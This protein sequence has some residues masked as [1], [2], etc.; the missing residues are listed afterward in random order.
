MR[1]TIRLNDLELAKLKQ[2]QALTGIDNTSTALKFA[3]EW[4]LN[5]I[6]IVSQSLISPNWE[7]MFQKKSKSSPSKKRL[8][9]EH[10]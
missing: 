8:Y 4:S 10:K 6:E 7:V 9:F 1:I 2:L 3:L 5:H